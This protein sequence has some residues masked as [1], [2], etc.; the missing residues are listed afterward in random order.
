MK[1][2]LAFKRT[3]IF[4][5]SSADRGGRIGLFLKFIFYIYTL[6]CSCP[7]FKIKGNYTLHDRWMGSRAHEKELQ[8]WHVAQELEVAQPSY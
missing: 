4:Y 7:H 5:W 1:L 6:D 3:R 8:G 2:Y